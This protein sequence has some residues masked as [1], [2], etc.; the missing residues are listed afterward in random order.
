MPDTETGAVA[1]E[2][3]THTLALPDFCSAAMLL[4]RL[5]TTDAEALGRFERGFHDAFSRAKS[6]RLARHIY[7]WDDRQQRVR[8]HLPYDDQQVF[9]TW[10]QAGDVDTAGAINIRLNHYQASR[11]GFTPPP[12]SGGEHCEILV[13]FS[14]RDADV[15][16]LH[17][18][19]Q[20]V[21]MEL[22]KQGYRSADAMCTDRLLPFYRH[23][24]GQPLAQRRLHGENRTLLRFALAEMAAL[25]QL[26]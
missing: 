26:I 14:H 20:Q 16:G 7:A 3:T 13:L 17:H 21:A 9:V 19:I 10:G 12:V 8:P 6:N 1:P 5:D 11:V 4:E 24:G 2:P 18:F 22:L 23:I 25:K 15:V